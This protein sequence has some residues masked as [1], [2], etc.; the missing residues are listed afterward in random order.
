MLR[1]T[2]ASGWD[3]SSVTNTKGWTCRAFWL[4]I[5]LRMRWVSTLYQAITPPGLRSGPRSFRRG[6]R[7]QPGARRSVHPR[8]PSR[9]A[10]STRR[11][12]R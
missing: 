8:R 12:S 3:T 7:A 6:A 5:S 1:S 11:A 4:V 2:R 9:A 10:R